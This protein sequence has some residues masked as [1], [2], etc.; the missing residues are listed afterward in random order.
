MRPRWGGS[1]RER[2]TKDSWSPWFAKVFV[3]CF[4][5]KDEF[6][7]TQRATET[8]LATIATC[9]FFLARCGSEGEASLKHATSIWKSPFLYTMVWL[10]RGLKAETLLQKRTSTCF[11]IQWFPESLA[12]CWLTLG[13]CWIFKKDGW[14]QGHTSKKQL[15]LIRFHRTHRTRVLPRSRTPANF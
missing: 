8:R 5:V 11:E 15:F 3:D 12:R 9:S 7:A 1:T 2:G 10:I 14:L 13:F 6:M 4:E